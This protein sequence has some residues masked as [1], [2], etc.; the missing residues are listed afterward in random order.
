MTRPTPPNLL[1]PGHV[2]DA[3]CIRL[4]NVGVN[5]DVV[6]E[7]VLEVVLE[8]VEEE[9]DVGEEGYDMLDGESTS[10]ILENIFLVNN[11]YEM[12]DDVRML[13]ENVYLGIIQTVI[14]ISKIV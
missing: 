12:V 5:V 9:G 11:G 8:L 3:T 6:D 7:L 14:S 4:P 1:I 2:R 13:Y 10:A